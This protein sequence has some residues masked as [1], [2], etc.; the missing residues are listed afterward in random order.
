LTGTGEIRTNRLAGESFS[1]SRIDQ[2]LEYALDGILLSAEIT[3]SMTKNI[4]TNEVVSN[5]SLTNL[6]LE[7]LDSPSIEMAV[8]R[9]EDTTSFSGEATVST[10][11]NLEMT[12]SGNASSGEGG[13]SFSGN[14]GFEYDFDLPLKFLVTKGRVEG[15]IFVDEN[16]DGEKNSDE[17]GVEG[18]VLAIEETEVASGKDG[19][20]KFPPLLPG[21]YELELQDV[22]QKLEPMVELPREV[23]VTRGQDERVGLPLNRLGE[24]RVE[25]YEDENQN[26]EREGGEGGVGGLGLV[27]SGP[28]RERRRTSNSAGEVKYQGLSPGEYTLAVDEETIPPRTSITTGNKEVGLKLAGG[29]VEVIEIGTYQEP[30]EIIFGQPPEADFLYAPLT[31]DPDTVVNFSGGLSVDPDGEI[32]N[33]SWDFQSDGEVDREGK[34]VSYDFGSPGTYEVQL[35]VTD[36]EGNEA[37]TSKK[38]EVVEDN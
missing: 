12:I 28:D 13:F 22:P 38:I 10:A 27:L 9:S 19:Y 24:I 16:G 6:R 1:Y 36:D 31:P 34:I 25:V 3:N 37:S 17:E 4:T 5:A 35:T 23:K 8:S 30:R 21:T 32:T 7:T 15:Y 29:Q 20:F 18:L 2:G 11:E 26:G 14:L 33:Y